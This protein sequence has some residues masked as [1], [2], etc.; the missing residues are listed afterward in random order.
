MYYYLVFTQVSSGEVHSLRFRH[1]IH[2][3]S[4]ARRSNY[5]CPLGKYHVIRATSH[6]E[7]SKKYRKRLR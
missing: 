5:N 6:I 4:E 7:A 2:P 3:F 1:R